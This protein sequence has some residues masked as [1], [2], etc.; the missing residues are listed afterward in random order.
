LGL[1]DDL[2][3]SVQRLRADNARKGDWLIADP[4][5]SLELPVWVDH[6]GSADTRWRRYRLESIE[7]NEPP[8]EAW[9]TIIPPEKL[10]D[11]P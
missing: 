6:V 9:T 2:V 8:P 1:S 3:D 11:T 5:G 10:S 7:S 4:T